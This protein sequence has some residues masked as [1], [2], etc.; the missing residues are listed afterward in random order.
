MKRECVEVTYIKATR[1]PVNIYNAIFFVLFCFV[2]F[3][4]KKK[5][6]KSIF[7]IKKFIIF[8]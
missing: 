3:Y 8:H 2:F 5:K 1:L 4:R 6:L 7:K